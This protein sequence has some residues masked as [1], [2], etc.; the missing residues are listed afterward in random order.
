MVIL[1]KN[2]NVVNGYCKFILIFAATKQIIMRKLLSISKI[3]TVLTVCAL[4]AFSITSCVDKDADLSRPDNGNTTTPNPFTYSTTQEVQLNVKY[5]VP[6][7]YKVLF[8]V[9]LENPF[10]ADA[11]GRIVKRTDIDPKVKRMTDGDGKYAGK[12][13]IPNYGNGDIYIYTS[14]IGV[15]QL[16]KTTIQ[17]N[18]IQADINWN[19]AFD[20][21]QN[22]QAR[23][24]V[25]GS[26]PKE[27][28]VL[29]EWDA[30]GRPEY[31]DNEG[32]LS[33]SSSFLSLINRTIPE[34]GV[35]TKYL[36]SADFEVQDEE[37][38]NRDVEV[39]VR[40]VGGTSS[41]QS[42]FGYYCYKRGDN[43]EK[44]AKAK[45]CLIFP[46]TKTGVGIRGGECVQ[47][48]YIDENGTDQGVDFPNGTMI[49]WFLTNDTFRGGN[50]SSSSNTFY[51]TAMLNND[52]RTHTA[53]FKINDFVVLSFEDWND[54]DYN[55]V[56]F[57]VWSNPREAIDTPDI[58]TVDPGEEEDD[59]SI[60]YKMTYKGILAFEDNWPS[61]GDYDLND[62]VVKYNSVLSFNTKNE[63]LFS[64][65]EFEALWSGAE[66]SNSFIYQI[67]AERSNVDCTSSEGSITMDQD[68]S[69]AT[70][71]VFQDMKQATGVNTKTTKITVNNKFKKPIDHELFGV[72]PYNPFI[73]VFKNT[74]YD[75]NEVHLVNHMPTEKAKI[76]TFQTGED[77]SDLDKGI[78]YVSSSKYPFAIHLSDAD[79][80]STKEKESVDKTYPKF[81]SWVESNGTK[82]KG[83]YM[84]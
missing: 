3:V 47:L 55:D 24:S 16:Y 64:E 65:D 81:A 58:P 34:G 9:Y 72:A 28:H 53:A 52:R 8:E 22:I 83:W 4:A 56:M 50:V 48:H 71:P 45:K 27:F 57:N 12:E 74:G 77:L 14:Y 39:K 76:E 5:Q 25:R 20:A 43:K 44:R 13:V 61:K 7:G 59:T 10:E 37:N 36:Q 70:I 15:P 78:Y 51:S 84:K 11:D 1:Y 17:E 33:L 30:S 19:T 63:I 46:N 82:D 41:A 68:L 31:L 54:H 69:L 38:Q 35:C 49:G 75:R 6:E 40:F 2:N 62:V 26:Y 80:Y 79:A 23:A 18:S 67:N 21:A 42:A 60:A 73:S 66:Y 29:G 32:A